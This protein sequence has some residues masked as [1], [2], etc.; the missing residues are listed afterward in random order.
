M[1]LITTA[2][3]VAVATIASLGEAAAQ[4]VAL[5]CVPQRPVESLASR[6]SP[7]DSV[8]INTAGKNAML[9]YSRPRANGREIFGGLIKYGQLWRTGADEPTTLHIAFPA[10]VAGVRVEPGSY[11]LYTVPGE[12]EWEV[13]LNRATSQWGHESSYAQ[14][15][16]QELG[17]GKVR[18]ERLPEHVEQFT[19]RSVPA[20]TGTS[21]VLDW[22]RTRVRIPIVPVN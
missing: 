10:T 7:Y 5:H 21:L 16:D 19:I 11:S 12:S 3:L 18:S 20:G 22:E 8:S 17:R 13:V 15:R 1:R 2:G 6:R 14:V 9:C 4:N